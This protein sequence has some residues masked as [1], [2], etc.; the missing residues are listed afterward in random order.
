MKITLYTIHCPS[1]KVL[2]M[3]LDKKQIQYEVVEDAEEV[4]KK[5]IESNIK[6]APLLDVDGTVMNFSDALKWLN[7]Q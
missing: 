5:G 1:C 3:K 4:I 6:S 7:Q 2:Q